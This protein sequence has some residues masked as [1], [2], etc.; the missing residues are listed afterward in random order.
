MQSLTFLLIF[1]FST[2]ILADM[3]CV[4]NYAGYGVINITSLG[5]RNG[6]PRFRDLSAISS[7]YYMYSFNPCFSF[8][9]NTCQNAA[10]C[11]ISSDRKTSYTLGTHNSSFWTLDGSMT[12]TL[13]YN[14]QSKTVTIRMVCSNTNEDTLEIL[15][16][17]TVNHYSM[18]LRSRC[19]CWNGCRDPLPPS[20]TVTPRSSSASTTK[21]GWIY[22]DSC[23]YHDSRYGIIDLSTVGSMTDRPAFKD[24]QSIYSTNYVWSYNPCYSFSE[25]KCHNVAGCQLDKTSSVSYPIAYQNAVY[26]LNMNNTRSVNPTI[27]YA[28]PSTNRRLKVQLICDRS[29]NQHRLEVVGETSVGEYLMQLT[30]PCACWNG[31]SH[32]PPNPSPNWNLWSIIGIAGGVIFLLFL[33]MMTCLFCSKPKRRSQYLTVGEKTP[34]FYVKN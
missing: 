31:C 25:H 19:A 16:E 9:E 8:S 13:T 5:L 1:G 4:F 14:S 32:R 10:V 23:Q 11:Q 27:V 22:Y 28:T 7:S 26:W 18:L 29:S 20:T 34:I 33:I 15:G 2:A 30:S 21:T 24:I 6:Q 12:P 17:Q 3:S